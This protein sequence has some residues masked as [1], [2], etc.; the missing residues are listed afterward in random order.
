MAGSTLL[1]DNAFIV[2]LKQLSCSERFPWYILA[3]TALSACNF[4]HEIPAIYR[5][6]LEHDARDQA[7][8]LVLTHKM[9]EALFKGSLLGGLPKGINALRAIKNALPDHL[10]EDPSP[11]VKEKLSSSQ[12]EERGKEFF[13]RT[14]GKVAERILKNITSSY[15]DLGDA[16]IKT[17]YGSVMSNVQILSPRETSLVMIATLIPLDVPPQLRGHLKGGLN[18]GATMEE[19]RAARAISMAVCQKCGVKWRGEVSNL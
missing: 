12:I 13:N 11:R 19:I 8:Q 6:A 3:A 15:K 4:P 18:N 16:A 5:Y 1:F 9:R 17:I 2:S 14:Y 7:S 10:H